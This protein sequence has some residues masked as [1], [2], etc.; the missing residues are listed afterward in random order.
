MKTIQEDA[1]IKGL[2]RHLLSK[3]LQDY[4]DAVIGDLSSGVEERIRAA[5][6]S[7]ATDAGLQQLV[8]YFVQYIAETVPQSLRSLGTLRILVGLLSSLLANEHLFL[9]PYLHQIMP[10][11][12]SCLLGKR[13]CENPTME[14]HWTLRDRCSVIISDVCRRFGSAYAT[15]L[16]RCAKTMGKT[17]LDTNRNACCHYGALIGISALG[18]RL[19]EIFIIANAESLHE[20]YSLINLEIIG[21]P[22]SLRAPDDDKMVIE[23]EIEQTPNLGSKDSSEKTLQEPINKLEDSPKEIEKCAAALARA[24]SLWLADTSNPVDEERIGAR[25]SEVKRL[26]SL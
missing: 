5:L 1:E 2:V 4:Y 24:I 25:V 21:A 7:T 14:D 23:D 13:L 10:T 16:P 22:S 19:I 17:L 11:L 6:Y 20:K 15:L 9:E 12:L 8:P 3:E 18:P 26:F